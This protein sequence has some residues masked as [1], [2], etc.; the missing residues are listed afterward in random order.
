MKFQFS[1]KYLLLTV[2]I[3]LVEVLIATKLSDIFFIR[4]YLGDVIVVM[5]LFTFVKSFVKINDQKLILGILIFSFLVEFAQYFNIAE[6]L[7]FRPGS[8]MYIVIG[9][10][11]SWIDNLCYTVGCLILY[12]LVKITNNE[13][14]TSTPNP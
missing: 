4:A 3:F 5:L 2:F 8:L 1:L 12:V 13:G 10:S 7:G 9:N 11:F 14:L 6:K